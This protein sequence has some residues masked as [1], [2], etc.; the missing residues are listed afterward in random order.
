MSETQSKMESQY[1]FSVD[2]SGH[3]VICIKS[4]DDY[5]YRIR[6]KDGMWRLDQA[7]SPRVTVKPKHQTV[8]DFIT[9]DEALKR[10]IMRHNKS[11]K[12]MTNWSPI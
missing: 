2:S 7:F 8:G 4:K 5:P 3:E 9:R 12:H 10:I 6:F 1:D 11:C